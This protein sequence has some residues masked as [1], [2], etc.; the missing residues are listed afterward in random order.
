MYVTNFRY[1]VTLT[2]SDKNWTFSKALFFKSTN[3]SLNFVKSCI[4]EELPLSGHL[5]KNLSVF[6]DSKK[7]SEPYS[8]FFSFIE[9]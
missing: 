3:L 1:K 8:I 7:K 4:S 2:G 6:F 9:I 5:A